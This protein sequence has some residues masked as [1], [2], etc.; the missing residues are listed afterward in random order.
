M[1]GDLF[2]FASSLR[3]LFGAGVCARCP[4]LWAL[5][6]RRSAKC[7]KVAF[8]LEKTEKTRY[9]ITTVH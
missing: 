3:V 1:A 7:E 4:E 6:L 2:L 9:P 8:P 5:C